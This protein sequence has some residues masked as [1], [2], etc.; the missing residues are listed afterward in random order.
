MVFQILIF[1]N[2]FSY[3][4]RVQL[5]EIVIL[6]R[7]WFVELSLFALFKNSFTSEKKS[8]AIENTFG[9]IDSSWHSEIVKRAQKIL[10]SLFLNNKKK[11]FFY[12]VDCSSNYLFASFQIRFLFLS[13][14]IQL[15]KIT[16]MKISNFRF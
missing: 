9:K 14:I 6:N 15:V 1:F 8:T 2:N 16:G 7:S 5:V 3:W 10:I 11:Q 4:T 13:N 12:Y